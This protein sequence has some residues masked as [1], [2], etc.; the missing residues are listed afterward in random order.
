M[1]I[2]HGAVHEVHGRIERAQAHG[3]RNVLKCQVRLA[4]PNSQ[5]TT[6]PPSLRCVG[7]DRQ[8]PIH[9]SRGIVEL[10]GY[11]GECITTHTQ[12]Y[13]VISTQMHCFPGQPCTFRAFLYAL[14]HPATRL[15]HHDAIRGHAI[16]A[17][18]TT[19]EFDRLAKELERLAVRVHG[20]PTDFHQSAQ[21]I[22]V[23][24]KAC[25]VLAP[26]LLIL[27]LFESP[28]FAR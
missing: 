12:R 2:R 8:S 24:T 7:I 6:K 18:Q 17:G 21:V 14:D 10:L 4:S 9:E 28:L 13:R 26:G 27:S 19:V 16:G 20:H 15:A 1:G 11:K 23:L 5:P 22:V 3:T 25:G